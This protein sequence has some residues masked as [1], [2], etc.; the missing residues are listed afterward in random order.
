MSAHVQ[1]SQDPRGAA[2][3]LPSEALGWP[4]FVAAT[5]NAAL[6]PPGAPRFA[7]AQSARLGSLR[8]VLLARHDVLPLL[9][10]L[11]VGAV[12]LG[13][14]GGSAGTGKGAVAVACQVLGSGVC[15]VNAHLAP[16][17]GRAAERSRMFR[18]RPLL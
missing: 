18:A 16:H 12:A 10:K 2:T 15:F 7:V 6:A 17:Q 1:V 9:S 5:A 8:L 13:A 14:D 11:S 3:P 4:A